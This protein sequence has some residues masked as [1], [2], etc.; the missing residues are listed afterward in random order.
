MKMACLLIILFS[1]SALAL[2]RPSDQSDSSDRSAARSER[3]L[4]ERPSATKDPQKPAPGKSGPTPRKPSERPSHSGASSLD[5]LRPGVENHSPATRPRL[6]L[7]LTPNTFSRQPNLS[8]G[9]AKQTPTV[10]SG[11]RPADLNSATGPRLLPKPAAPPTLNVTPA[12]PAKSPTVGGLATAT[13]K[14]NPAVL[15]GT[16]IKAR[17]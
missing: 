9:T 10:P 14:K 4:Q 3:P 17:P 7:R 2:G 5:R 1:F 11:P 12:R 8:L 16:A 6:E 13:T 15:N